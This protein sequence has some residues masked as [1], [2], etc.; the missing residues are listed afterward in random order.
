MS[1]EHVIRMFP[2]VC[3]GFGLFLAGAANLL[4][5]R[6]GVGVPPASLA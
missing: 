5:L 2:A 3:A 6:R 1:D 4:L